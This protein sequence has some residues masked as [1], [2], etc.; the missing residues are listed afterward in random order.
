M[1]SVRLLAIGYCV[2]ITYHHKRGC[3]LFP[4]LTTTTKISQ[5]NCWVMVCCTMTYLVTGSH[6]DFPLCAVQSPEKRQSKE[7]ETKYLPANI[8]KLA[9]R[10]SVRIVPVE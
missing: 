9:E 6:S 5:I 8:S 2:K 10:K 4:T 7:I 1:T 3:K